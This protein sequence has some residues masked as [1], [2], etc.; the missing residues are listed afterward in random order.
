MLAKAD[1]QREQQQVSEVNQIVKAFHEASR[2]RSA[3]ARRRRRARRAAE[4]TSRAGDGA[5]RERRE[6]RERQPGG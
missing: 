6:R 5:D 2:I 4:P 3:C 1:Q